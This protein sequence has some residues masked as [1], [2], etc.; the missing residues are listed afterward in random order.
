M[1][2]NEYDQIEDCMQWLDDC[3]FTPENIDKVYMT[4]PESFG[5]DFIVTFRNNLDEEKQYCFDKRYRN[6]FAICLTF[7]R[8]IN[9]FN[10]T[11]EK[12]VQ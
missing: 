6:I 7:T 8:Y 1:S 10:L 9:T 3:G 4:E 12:H 11:A 2:H 5:G